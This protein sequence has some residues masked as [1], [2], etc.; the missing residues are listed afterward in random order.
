MTTISQK[1]R[2]L[3][4]EEFLNLAPGTLLR[5]IDGGGEKLFGLN[6]GIVISATYHGITVQMLHLEDPGLHRFF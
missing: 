4:P 2:R 3:S 5:R 1:S 6:I